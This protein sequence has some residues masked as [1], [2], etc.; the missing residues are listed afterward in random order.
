MELNFKT[1]NI[2]Y[3]T[4]M[5]INPLFD[6]SAILASVLE[7]LASTKK[8]QQIQSYDGMGCKKTLFRSKSFLINFS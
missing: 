2:T 8:I 5:H 7:T 1:E 6:N 3:I 4:E